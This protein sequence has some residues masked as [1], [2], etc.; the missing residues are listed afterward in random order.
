[1]R[2]REMKVPFWLKR[3]TPIEI[4]VAVVFVLYI[5]LPVSTPKALGPMI[6]SPVGFISIFCII[7]ALFFFANPILAVLYLGVAYMLLFRSV[8]KPLPPPPPPPSA[9]KKRITP[10]P[11]PPASK[12]LEEE[13]ISNMAAP[14]TTTTTSTT[15]LPV[16]DNTN[17]AS[18]I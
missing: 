9:I 12:T 5:V 18:A 2:V 16:S 11:A 15:F 1:M 3:I 14:A 10:P 7:L 17:G 8:N 4:A 6:H 13:I